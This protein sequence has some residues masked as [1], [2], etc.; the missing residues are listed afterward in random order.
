[1]T[2]SVARDYLKDNI[3]CNAISPARVHTPFVDGFVAKNYP[4]REKEMMDVL[5]RAQPIG[6]MAEPDEVA[7]LAV[8]LCS[9]EASFITGQNY[10]LDGGYMNL[11]G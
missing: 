8:W 9:D 4:G 10:P 6:R 1:M 3:R 5:G 11:R 2:F 7:N